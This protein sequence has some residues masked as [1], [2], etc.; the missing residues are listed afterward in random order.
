MQNRI[1]ESL[2]IEFLISALTVTML[3]LPACSST[4]ILL[5]DSS[6]S[7]NESEYDKSGRYICTLSG[8]LINSNGEHVSGAVVEAATRDYENLWSTE[9]TTGID[10]KYSVDLYWVNQPFI[11]ADVFPNPAQSSLT[12]SGF[13]YLREARTL[14]LDIPVYLKE[15]I[16]PLTTV[17]ITMYSLSF[18]L[19]R[20]TEDVVNRR[21]LQ[22]SFTA[23]DIETGLTI[24]GSILTLRGVGSISSPDS[25]LKSFIISDTLLAI[26]VQNAKSYVIGE[27]SKKLTP[28]GGRYTPVIT[29]SGNSVSAQNDISLGITLATSGWGCGRRSGFFVMTTLLRNWGFPRSTVSCSEKRPAESWKAHH[30]QTRSY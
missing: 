26:A 29:A 3:L 19:G 21:L 30:A 7:F 12:K 27:E 13:S 20:M 5:E 11:Y 23:Q 15:V 22:L 24:N 14:T 10:G 18:A 8:V 4:F 16:E 9:S 6:V 1:K 25:L 2:R 17:P 28:K